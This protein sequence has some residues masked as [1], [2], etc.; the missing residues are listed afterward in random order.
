[1]LLSLNRCKYKHYSYY[2]L[3]CACND[4]DNCPI[5]D[6]ECAGQLRINHD[7]HEAK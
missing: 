7:C 5:G 3:E 6:C 2:F 1:M 4:P